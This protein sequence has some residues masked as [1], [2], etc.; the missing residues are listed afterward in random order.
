MIRP[1]SKTVSVLGNPK[2]YRGHEGQGLIIMLVGPLSWLNFSTVAAE[3]IIWAANQGGTW[4]PKFTHLHSNCKYHVSINAIAS[5][6]L[7]ID[8]TPC[9]QWFELASLIWPLC[10]LTA[11][12][13]AW[14][15]FASTLIHMP[16]WSMVCPPTPRL[17]AQ[18]LM[19]RIL[20][21]IV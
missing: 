20:S 4:T 8:K 13:S 7:G 14:S 9:S 12:G 19:Q 15:F 17:G 5:S 10:S 18:V 2:I 6:Q 16:W 1:E 21:V 11:L 3:T